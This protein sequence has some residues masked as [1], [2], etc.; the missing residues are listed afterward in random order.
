MA[1][2]L[3]DHAVRCL[4]L[5]SADRLLVRNAVSRWHHVAVRFYCFLH[6]CSDNKILGAHL[7][8]SFCNFLPLVVVRHLSFQDELAGMPTRCSAKW[9][10][11]S[12]V[13]ENK[14]A[15]SHLFIF[16]WAVKKC[17]IR[18][19]KQV[20]TI[21]WHESCVVGG[22]CWITCPKSSVTSLANAQP[23]PRE[24]AKSVDNNVCTASPQLG[25][26][27]ANR[28]VPIVGLSQ[29]WIVSSSC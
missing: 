11:C 5:L 1:W 19:A 27:C 17:V 10:Q 13:A 22:V 12:G 15:G 23:T 3:V 16:Q 14:T 9:R 18:K 25:T 20:V 21:W 6:S 29:S 24:L 2:R 4:S 26:L 7:I 8:V 28:C